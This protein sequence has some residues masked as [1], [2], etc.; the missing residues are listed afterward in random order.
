MDFP[1]FA[2]VY[3]KRAKSPSHAEPKQSWI[4]IL[5]EIRS[6]WGW[7]V[8]DSSDFMLS[9]VYFKPAIQHRPAYIK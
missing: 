2:I 8:A 6:P 3:H 7:L 5:D 9:F 4:S 1:P